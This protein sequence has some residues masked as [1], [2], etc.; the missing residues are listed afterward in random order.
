M[1]EIERGQYPRAYSFGAAIAREREEAVARAGA[2]RRLHEMVRQFGP[3]G[4]PL[5]ELFDECLRSGFY[6]ARRYRRRCGYAF[7][8]VIGE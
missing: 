8:E 5:R 4:V 1:V 2:R 6:S 3:G 7:K